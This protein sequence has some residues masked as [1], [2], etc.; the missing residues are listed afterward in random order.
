[1]IEEAKLKVDNARQKMVRT[2]QH[3]EEELTKIRA[4]K[5]NPS[6][7]DGIK[8]D[9]Y[10]TETP[11]NQVATVKTSD[12]K[13]IVIQPWEKEMLEGVEKAILAANIGFTPQNDGN[14][15]RLVMPTLTEERRL[16]LV[17]KVREIAEQCRVSVRNIRRDFN[18]EIKQMI[19]DG[20]SE[21]VAKT[22]ENSNQELTDEYI[23]V[24]D[25][26]IE[27]KEKE[28]MTV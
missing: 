16:S 8:V 9:Y 13:T 20:L 5:V 2:I 3:L 24:V 23:K 15:I 7:L 17:K 22:T 6:M 19:K 27:A 11:L 26:H 4:G 18:E 10:G 12:Y 14:V 28:I 25:N 1:M 21:D